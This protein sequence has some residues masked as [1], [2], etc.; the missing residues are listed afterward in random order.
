MKKSIYQS[1]DDLPLFLN[2]ELIA[3][4]L[5]VAP[6]SAYELGT[7]MRRG[8]LMGLQ[9]DDLN[10][11]TGGMQARAVPRSTPHLRNHGAG[12]RYGRKNLVGDHRPC[13]SGN[14][15]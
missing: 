13:V 2:A 1:Y 10:F 7:G 11:Q 5:G 6:S 4:V 3:K 9:W 15:T 12:K 14:H 8:E